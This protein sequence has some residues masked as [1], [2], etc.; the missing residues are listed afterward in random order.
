M[1]LILAGRFTGQIFDNLKCSLVFNSNNFDLTQSTDYKTILINVFEGFLDYTKSQSMSLLDAKIL[2]FKDHYDSNLTFYNSALSYFIKLIGK[3]DGIEYITGRVK[4]YEECLSKF[5]RKYL[6]EISSE[7][8]DYHIIDSLS[9][10]IGVRVV[11]FYLEDVEKIRKELSN[12]FR[13]VDS[14]DKTVQLEK[15]DDKFGYKS[16]HLDLVLKGNCKSRNYKKYGGIQ[17]EVQIRTVIQDAWSILDHKIKYKKSIPQNLKRRIN[18]LSALF[19]IADD[20]FLRIKEE[21]ALEEN[22]ISERI[23]KGSP[24]EK[25]VPL[26]V[27]K[28]LF[29]ALKYFPHYNFIE[30]KVDGFVQEIL[31]QKKDFSESDLNDV[32]LKHLDD[33]NQMQ[34]NN[35]K[36]KLNPYTKIRYCLY[37]SNRDIFSGLLT[38]YQLDPI[39]DNN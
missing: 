16:L 24:I 18:R 6:P 35:A 37:L 11:C 31:D 34:A 38:S 14:T 1:E 19:E 2:E 29:V 26:D 36:K 13:E 22:K 20:E 28:F 15:T 3:V 30:F 23:K 10:F 12:Y 8:T 33:V 21:I 17:I 9:D 25:D 4:D 32:L 5:E 39:T 7:N 27:F